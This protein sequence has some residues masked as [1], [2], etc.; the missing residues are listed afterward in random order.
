MDNAE[1]LT[2][3]KIDLGISTTNAYDGRLVEYLGSAR[4]AIIREG[5]TLT[6][7]LEDC[8]LVVDYAGWLWNKRRTGEAIPRSLRWRLNN[9]LLSEK[10]SG[11]DA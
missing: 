3:L 1:M 4:A 2:A 8:D 6:D 5:I 7:S 9:R 11:G 10:M